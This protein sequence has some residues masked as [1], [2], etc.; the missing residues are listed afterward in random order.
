MRG[1]PCP[2]CHHPDKHKIEIAI[3]TKAMAYR[4]MSKAYGID[5][6]AFSK[7]R[8]QHME[9][10]DMEQAEKELRYALA[11]AS[12]LAPITALTGVAEKVRAFAKNLSTVIMHLHQMGYEAAVHADSLMKQA[13]ELTE[14]T[15]TDAVGREHTTDAPSIVIGQKI[16]L[17][18]EATKVVE[19]VSKGIQGS[20]AL[21]LFKRFA[22][23]VEDDPGL[24][25]EFNIENPKDEK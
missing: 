9:K 13:I 23:Q 6:G 1:P 20:A 24:T 2:I 15:H 19:R 18:G 3:K 8:K 17:I 12:T 16:A 21:E 4:D 5:K 25:I 7:H 14:V 22:D 10:P 11:K